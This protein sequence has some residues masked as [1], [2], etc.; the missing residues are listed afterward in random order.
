MRRVAESIKS[1]RSSLR[2]TYLA[3]KFRNLPSQVF[4]EK[5]V[6]RWRWSTSE[7]RIPHEESVVILEVFREVLT[8]Q[9]MVELDKE[10]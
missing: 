8:I 3:H 1:I 6:C 7:T 9:I 4:P 2:L 5:A 10:E